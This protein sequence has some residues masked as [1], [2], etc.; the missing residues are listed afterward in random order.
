MRMFY[1]KCLGLLLLIILVAF[2]AEYVVLHICV[3]VT[4][5]TIV[6]LKRDSICCWTILIGAIPS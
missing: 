3:Q 2:A 1:G 6:H 4:M 5:N